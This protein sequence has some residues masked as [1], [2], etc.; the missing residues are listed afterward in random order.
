MDIILN[1]T[2]VAAALLVAMLVSF[3]VGHRLGL[4][5]SQEDAAGDSSVVDGAIFALLGLLIAFT[6]SGAAGRYDERR[7]MI[8]EEANTISTAYARIDLLP[9]SAQ[10]PVRD[11]FRRYV[12]TRL[13]AYR[14]LPDLKAA[15]AGLDRADA[16]QREIWSAGVAAATGSQPVTMLLLPAVNAM[17]DIAT[18]RT[19]AARMHPPLV[20]FLLLFGLAV[21]SALLAGRAMAS[22]TNRRWLHTFVYAAAL[23]G[24]VYVIVDI[25]FPR[26]GLIRVDNFDKLM[27]DVRQAMN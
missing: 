17:G 1:A 22:R 3:E 26:F 14:A 25:E 20:I 18:A 8:L 15:Q 16:L 6:F 9:A 7:K 13:A 12:D 21:L 27:V 24:A 19:A 2:L 10:P 5:R 11:L 4:R 23:T